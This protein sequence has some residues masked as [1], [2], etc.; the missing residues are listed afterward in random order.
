MEYLS[1]DVNELN[2]S[3]VMSEVN[4]VGDNTNEWWIDTGA[5]RH[6]C[7]NKN[8]F[9]SYQPRNNGEQHFM[10]KNFIAKVKG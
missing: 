9:T 3:T 2:L 4:M 5:T 10:K 6:V 1:H 7:S 8:M